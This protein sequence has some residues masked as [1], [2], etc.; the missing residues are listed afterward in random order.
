MYTAM[1][2]V[3]WL[4]DVSMFVIMFCLIINGKPHS[5]H[6]LIPMVIQM[7]CYLCTQK[8][9]MAHSKNIYHQFSRYLSHFHQIVSSKQLIK[10]LTDL[11]KYNTFTIAIVFPQDKVPEYYWAANWLKAYPFKR[12]WNDLFDSITVQ[13]HFDNASTHS[14]AWNHSSHHHIKKCVMLNARYPTLLNYF[15]NDWKVEHQPYFPWI[16]E[17]I[18]S[19]KSI[20]NITNNKCVSSVWSI[21]LIQREDSRVLMDHQ[22]ETDIYDSL[23][24]HLDHHLFKINRVSFKGLHPIE[25]A[26]FMHQHD[27]IIGA[28]GAALTNLLFMNRN[29][30]RCDGSVMRPALI[31]I[32]FRFGWCGSGKHSQQIE[33][34]MANQKLLNRWHQCGGQYYK[35]AEFFAL[36]HAFANDSLRYLELN[37][38]RYGNYS[39]GIHADVI[40][41]DTKLLVKEIMRIYNDQQYDFERQLQI[42]HDLYH[43]QGMLYPGQGMLYPGYINV[44]LT[45]IFV[46]GMTIIYVQPMCKARDAIRSL[47]FRCK[48]YKPL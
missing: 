30:Q 33:V 7:E 31:E 45:M 36:L 34:N 11:C 48:R 47:N 17:W 39:F 12:I 8:K 14:H 2:I 40:Y 9:Q 16:S 24:I 37:A 27:I 38:V 18:D 25:Q 29:K 42:N 5:V 1:S 10:P 6:C 32:G 21:G 44:M 15:D 46:I 28:H 13:I 41:V 19:Y 4:E 3:E 23:S 35:K 26:K 43:R 20:Y 22:T